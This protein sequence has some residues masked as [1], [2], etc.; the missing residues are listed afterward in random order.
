MN[1]TIHRL[2]KPFIPF[3]NALF[4]NSIEGIANLPLAGPYILAANHESMPDSWVMSNIIFASQNTKVWFIARDNFWFARWWVRLVGPLL[5][6]LLIDWR[7]PAKVLDKALAVLRRQ[8]V[9]GI[10]PEGTRNPDKRSLVLGKTG[11]ARLAL[12]A[13][14]PVV[15]VGYIG[16][17][18][19][20]VWDV[21]KIYV[22]KRQKSRIIIGQPIDLSAYYDKLITR[23]LL[24][25]VTDKI[26]IE[27]GKLCGKKPRLHQSV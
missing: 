13:R 3:V 26:M 17:P 18:I 7:S 23:E 15:P 27:I 21:F 25:E 20:S 12:E 1:I 11:V 6:S 2:A 5:G 22:W 19:E 16:Q 9:V 8:E 10:F 24:Y 14:C 4:T